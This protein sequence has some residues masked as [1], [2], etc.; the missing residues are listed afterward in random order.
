MASLVFDNP[1]DPSQQIVSDLESESFYLIITSG[2]LD[3]S[4]MP[5]GDYEAIAISPEPI[6]FSAAPSKK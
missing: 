6:D 2:F 5:T 4:N 3:S 1:A